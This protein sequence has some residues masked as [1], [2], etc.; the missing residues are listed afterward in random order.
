MKDYEAFEGHHIDHWKEQG[1]VQA[2][3]EPSGKVKEGE[4]MK[5]HNIEV[6]RYQIENMN[7]R[8][9]RIFRTYKEALD[10][11]KTL[12]QF[13]AAHGCWRIIALLKES[14]I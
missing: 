7:T 5:S 2:D 8:E 1:Y 6:I 3:T 4:P 10:D 14:I 9:V 12:E 11:Y 13:G